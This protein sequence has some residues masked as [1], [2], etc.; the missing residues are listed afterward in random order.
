VPL[1]DVLLL[2][3]HRDGVKAVVGVVSVEVSDGEA[4]RQPVPHVVVLV[5]HVP[6]AGAQCFVGAAAHQDGRRVPDHVPPD[7]PGNKLFGMEHALRVRMRGASD[8]A[9]FAVDLP[10]ARKDEPALGVAVE[11]RDAAGQELRL[12][13]VVVV[14]QG[15]VRCRSRTDERGPVRRLA[16]PLGHRSIRHAWVIEVWPH[17]VANS[18]TPASVLGDGQRPRLEGL[19]QDRFDRFHDV[20]RSAV[21]GDPD[22]DNGVLLC[23]LPSHDPLSIGSD[24]WLGL[25]RESAD[26]DLAGPSDGSLSPDGRKLALGG[27]R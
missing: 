13:A 24:G 27:Q 21:R 9:T 10:G 20:S 15:D 4:Q 26:R 22:V 1:S 5:E 14:E 18:V 23:G 25:A 8:H 19:R 7:E 2:L 6:K 3:G 17:G 12:P 11:E 16:D